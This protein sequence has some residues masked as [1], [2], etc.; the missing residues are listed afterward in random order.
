MS[1]LTWLP[2]IT[3]LIFVALG[4]LVF[5]INAYILMTLL[6]INLISY[7]VTAYD[8]YIAVN[9]AKTGKTKQRISE[10]TLYIFALLGGWPAALIAQQQFRHKTQ[11]TRFKVWFW[12]SSLTN[13]IAG[14][15]ILYF[16]ISSSS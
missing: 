4:Y 12:L 15:S 2:V 8:K 5:N 3:L 16:V 10:Q 7:A 6:G 1:L 9:N 13:L 14:S 11:K